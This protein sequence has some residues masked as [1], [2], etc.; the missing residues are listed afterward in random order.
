MHR[1]QLV[2]SCLLIAYSVGDVGHAQESRPAGED[3]AA[4]ALEMVRLLTAGQFEGASKLTDPSLKE[5]MSPE[6]TRTAWTIAT[7]AFGDVKSI[8][9]PEVERGWLTTEVYIPV[10]WERHTSRLKIVLNARR[11]VIGYFLVGPGSKLTLTSPP[12]YLDGDSFTEEPITFGLEDWK[13]QGILTMPREGHPHAAVV[14]VHGSGP[15]DADETYGQSKPFRDLAHGLAGRGIATL[16]YVKR[17]RAHPLRAARMAMTLDAE[18]IDDAVEALNFLREQ[19]SLRETPLYVL[20]H[21]LGGMCAPH[22]A[23]RDGGV[24]G[25]ILLAAPAREFE[26]VLEEQLVYQNELGL[27]PGDILKEMRAIIDDLRHRRMEEGDTLL[28]VPREYFYDVCDRDG[29][30]MIRVAR[31]LNCRILV[32]QGGRDYQCTREDFEKLEKGLSR[33]EHATFRFLPGMNHFF[34]HGQ[35]KAI[36]SEYSKPN[37]VDPKVIVI[38]TDWCIPDSK[39]NDTDASRVPSDE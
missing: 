15:H 18:V 31:E 12:K 13:L 33:H 32:L 17:T 30:A 3:V 26:D 1:V 10:E 5:Q 28:G 14:L 35:G 36:P 37:F 22:I 7:K 39:K 19:D 2:M 23:K 29:E 27:L 8:G 34:A 16:R 11:K 25:I 24:D 21:S 9:E 38:L 20:G 4:I 6:A